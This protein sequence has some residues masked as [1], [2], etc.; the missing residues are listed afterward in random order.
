MR[1]DGRRPVAPYNPKPRW[2]EG[3]VR[4]LREMGA[5]E[6][7]SAIADTDGDGMNDAREV[8]AGSDTTNALDVFRLEASVLGS[9][10]TLLSWRGVTGRIYQVE[11]KNALADDWH[12]IPAFTNLA[13][14]RGTMSVTNEGASGAR[15][16]SGERGR[17]AE[18]S[19][20]SA[21]VL[22][23]ACWA[24]CAV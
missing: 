19:R 8:M 1:Q 22:L 12:A 18:F 17:F 6:F 5:Y 23:A 2:P 21:A 9:D 3:Y 11:S 20:L 4:I 24:R 15:L 13:G 10:R 7:A 16:L 14:E